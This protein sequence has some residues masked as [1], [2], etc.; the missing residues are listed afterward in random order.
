MDVSLNLRRRRTFLHILSSL[1]ENRE[2]EKAR[3]VCNY[4]CSE[5]FSFIHFS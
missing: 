2:A 3:F 1:L 5:I 4:Y